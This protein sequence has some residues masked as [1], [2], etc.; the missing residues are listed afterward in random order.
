MGETA[1]VY[2][3]FSYELDEDPY[4][5]YRWMRDEAPLYHNEALD[6]FALTRFQDNLDAFVDKTT[7]SS[8]W[9]TSLELMDGPKPDS[10]LMIWMDPPAHNRYRGLVN[11]AFTKRQIGSLEPMVR[12]IAVDYLDALVGRERFDVVKDF[13]A[14]LP[15][16]V[17]ST[18]L[19]IPESDRRW[20]QESSNSMLHRDP[21]NPMPLPEA[22]DASR[23]VHAYFDEQIAERRARPRD[24]MM[25]HLTQVEWEDETGSVSRLSDHD[26]RMFLTLL[27][28]A[29]NE[30]VTKFL[31]TVYYELWRNPD[32][33]RVLLDEPRYIPNCVE[34]TLRYDPPS[35]YQGRVTT[36]E[37]VLHG[38]RVPGNAR[39]LL[40]NG[41]SGRDERRF[42]DPDRFDVRREI[43]MHLGLGWGRHLCLGASLAR[44]ESR[45]AIEELLR[46]FPDYEIPADGIERMHSSN[47]RGLSG[48]VLEPV[49]TG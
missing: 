7:Y 42:P 26:I 38:R 12:G 16:D 5:V 39:M 1:H 3:P 25:T 14:R 40:I 15:M 21:G 9:G 29:G 48:L 44:L 46:R 20:V 6:F 45:I 10:G 17:I 2:D 33:R 47:V 27:A 49:R 24:D 4:P 18:L 35:Q 43:E 8:E 31:A 32:E 30:T 37:I 36:R 28:T 34:E 19:G 41:A 22:M 13:T 23:Q 11:K